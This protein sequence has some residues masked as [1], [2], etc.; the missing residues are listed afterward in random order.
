MSGGAARVVFAGQPAAVERAV[1]DRADAVGAG[2]PGNTARSTARVKIEYGGCSLTGRTVPRPLGDPHAT[3]RSRGR[4]AADVPTMRT[5]PACT[6]SV[7]RAERLFAVGVRIETVE[8]VEIDVV[9]CPGDATTR[10]THA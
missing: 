3:R 6:R 9:E 8:L 1:D 7:Q 5:L 4:Y 10:H 2:T